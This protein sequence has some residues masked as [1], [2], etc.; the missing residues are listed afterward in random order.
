MMNSSEHGRHGKGDHGIAAWIRWSIVAFPLVVA[1]LFAVF[2][3][4][5][6]TRSAAKWWL[7]GEGSLVEIVTFIAMI[8]AAV[9]AWMLARRSA[10]RESRWTVGFYSLFGFGMFV[11]AMEEVAWGQWIFGFDPPQAIKEINEQEEL[12]IHNLPGLMGNSEYFRLAFAVGAATGFLLSFS[13]RFDSIALPRMLWSWV[14]VLLLFSAFDLYLDFHPIDYHTYRT[15]GVYMS[16]V[17]EM[18]IGMTGLA[19][20]WLNSRLLETVTTHP[21]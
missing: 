7:R 15:F 6:E 3:W 12:T 17:V 19:Y 4:N 14:L 21:R 16:E 9:Q 1:A 10:Q 13:R 2:L 5:G 8:L 18:L 11:T 20:V